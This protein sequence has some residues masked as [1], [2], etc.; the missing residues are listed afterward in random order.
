MTPKKVYGTSKS[1][2]NNSGK[3][4]EFTFFENAPQLEIINPSIFEII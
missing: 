1:E 4:L 3:Y 2:K